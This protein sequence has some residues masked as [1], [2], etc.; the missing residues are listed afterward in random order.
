MLGERRRGRGKPTG[1]QGNPR[2]RTCTGD[3]DTGGGE[4]KYFQKDGGVHG[5]RRRAVEGRA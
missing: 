5:K 1:S 3:R 2:G 4:E